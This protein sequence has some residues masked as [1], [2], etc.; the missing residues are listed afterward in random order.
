MIDV[1][2]KKMSVFFFVFKANISDTRESSMN[3]VICDLLANMYSRFMDP[4]TTPDA[5]GDF[6]FDCRNILDA[7]ALRK[8]GFEVTD[9]GKSVAEYLSDSK[10]VKKCICFF[11]LACFFLEIC[12]F[13][14]M[15]NF[16]NYIFFLMIFPLFALA[17]NQ[18]NIF[19]NYDSDSEM[20]MK[21]YIPCQVSLNDSTSSSL[22]ASCKVHGNSTAIAEKMPLNLKFE[23]KVDLY[24]MG[25][26]KKY[27]LLSNPFDPV[28][29]RN[30]IVLDFAKEL[31]FL[32]TV[33]NEFADVWINGIYYGNY[34]LTEKVQVHKSRV[35]IDLA[36]GDILIQRE[37]N[38]AEKNQVY[39][40][41]DLYSV[42][43]L[44]KEPENDENVDLSVIGKVESAME[45]ADMDSVAKYIDIPSMV[46]FYILEE[47]FSNA[48]C[49]YSSVY[50]FT[51][52]GRLYSGPAWDFDLSMGNT[53][54]KPKQKAEGFT[55][56]QSWWAELLLIPEFERLV[57]YRYQN[58]QPLINNLYEGSDTTKSRIQYLLDAYGESFYRNWTETKWK[59]DS[60]YTTY[61]AQPLKTFDENV[62]SLKKW[63]KKRNEWL[64]KNFVNINDALDESGVVLDTSYLARIAENVDFSEDSLNS[65]YSSSSKRSLSSSSSKK[66]SSSSSKQ[67]LG[68]SSSKNSSSS[69]QK[70]DGFSI[71]DF[72]ES[73]KNYFIRVDGRSMEI[74]SRNKERIEIFDSIGNLVTRE[75]TNGRKILRLNRSGVFVVKVGNHSTTVRVH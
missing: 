11:F 21:E 49:N 3:P 47:L 45:S 70:K 13:L 23:K 33:D 65:E 29:M 40:V 60:L 17:Q 15:L 35:N 4:K 61:G 6:V 59:E 25:A 51:K 26:A 18:V 72:A 58:L 2:G 57:A 53:S 39:F 9:V 36:S 73:G 48:D 1:V 63:L 44:V 62:D 71:T 52:K 41:T 12:K 8:I 67:K 34:L 69:S 68:S 16:K 75:W 32:Y 50:F 38:R 42:R 5:K 66:S 10:K 27:V 46:D 7:E 24:Q 30:K 31:S 55:C 74:S 64:L 22:P 56:K 14:R 37:K 54:Y 43:F 19:I 28:L 20:N